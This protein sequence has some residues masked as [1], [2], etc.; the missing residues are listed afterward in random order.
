M[1]LHNILILSIV[2]MT[3]LEEYSTKIVT[4]R[5]R[6]MMRG[7]S[8]ILYRLSAGQPMKYVISIK[9]DQIKRMK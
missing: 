9:L 2:Q 7:I 5:D 4:M 3:E 8:N 6:G 1:K